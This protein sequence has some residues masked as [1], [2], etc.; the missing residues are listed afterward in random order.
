[1]QTLFKAPLFHPSKASFLLPFVN[2]EFHI[3]SFFLKEKE[4]VSH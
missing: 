4:P 2:I 3:Y 1:M